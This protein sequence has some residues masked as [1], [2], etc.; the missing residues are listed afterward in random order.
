MSEKTVQQPVRGIVTVGMTA[1]EQ[2]LADGTAVYP[3]PVAEWVKLQLTKKASVRTGRVSPSSAGSCLRRQMLSY[4]GAPQV[5]PPLS[6][7]ALMDMGTWAHL[8]WQAAGLSQGFLQTAEVPVGDDRV[9]GHMDGV[10]SDG[11]GFELKTT[12]ARNFDARMVHGPDKKHLLQIYL[13]QYLSGI[14]MFSLVYACRASGDYT[15]YLVPSTEETRE[16]ALSVIGILTAHIDGGTIPE[17]LPKCVKEVGQEF[18]SCPFRLSCS[19][20]NH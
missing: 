2:R 10:L 7:Q 20:F 11:T 17:M 9:W 15:E 19:Q 12:G 1:W 8:R 6:A 3:E 4:Y 5:S 14:N 13:Y 16:I 18:Q